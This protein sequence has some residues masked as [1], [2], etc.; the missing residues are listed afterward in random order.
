MA[1]YPLYLLRK[2]C[3]T[4]HNTII[5]QK[6]QQSRQDYWWMTMIIIIVFK[7]THM[8]CWPKKRLLLHLYVKVW[9]NLKCR[10]SY[11]CLFRTSSHN[12]DWVDHCQIN[13]SVFNSILEVYNRSPWRLS[14]AGSPVAT[15]G[16]SGGNVVGFSMDNRPQQPVCQSHIAQDTIYRYQTRK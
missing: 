11:K 15:W 4:F 13:L 12:A 6:G 16:S 5:W 8:M 3:C 10:T 7:M 1:F 14:C 9:L 2:V